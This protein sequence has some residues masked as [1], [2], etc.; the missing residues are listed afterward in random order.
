MNYAEFTPMPSK[1]LVYNVS[2]FNDMGHF[3]YSVNGE[4]SFKSPREI[5]DFVFNHIYKNYIEHY[6]IQHPNNIT[7]MHFRLKKGL[8]K[9]WTYQF[10]HNGNINVVNVTYDL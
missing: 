9:K 8:E 6:Y 7:T 10:I 3:N 4:S 2:C 5:S 1:K